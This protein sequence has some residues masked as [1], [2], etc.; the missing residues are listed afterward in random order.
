VVDPA[1]HRTRQPGSEPTSAPLPFEGTLED[2]ADTM[3]HELGAW[4]G[5]DSDNV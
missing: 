4:A 5:F 1:A 2:L 3:N